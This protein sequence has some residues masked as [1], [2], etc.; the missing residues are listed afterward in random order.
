MNPPTRSPEFLAHLR[1]YVG[2][3]HLADAF[4]IVCARFREELREDAVALAIPAALVRSWSELHDYVDAN[5]YGGLCDDRAALFLFP[6]DS[7]DEEYAEAFCEFFNDVTDALDSW[8]AAG[9]LAAEVP[10]APRR[11]AAEYRAARAADDWRTAQ[12]IGKDYL[13]AQRRA[14]VLHNS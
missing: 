3:A 14:R 5:E 8:L 9:F 10:P 6:S 2:G 12:A 1:R 13:R 4:A 11:V 7:D